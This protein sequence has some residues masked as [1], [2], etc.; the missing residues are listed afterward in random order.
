M[1]KPSKPDKSRQLAS[2]HYRKEM[3]EKSATVVELPTALDTRYER[4][5]LS[6]V[7]SSDAAGERYHYNSA[8]RLFD[9]L[10]KHLPSGVFKHFT[11]FIIE[12]DRK[13]H[14]YGDQL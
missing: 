12:Y 8:K 4:I 14:N 9:Q 1:K 7:R 11:M 10:I 5:L 3:A 13:H 2:Y 6:F